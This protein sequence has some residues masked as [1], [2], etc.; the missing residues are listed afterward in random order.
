MEASKA[1][2]RKVIQLEYEYAVEMGKPLFAVV[3]EEASIEK[4][5]KSLGIKVLETENPHKL[6]EFKALVLSKMVRFWCD[7]R[8]IKLAV[9]ETMAEFSRRTELV[10]WISGSEAVNAGALAKEFARLTK[11]NSELREQLTHFSASVGSY[12]GLNY[13]QMHNLLSKTPPDILLLSPENAKILGS[14]AEALGDKNPD[15]LHLLWM[16]SG[17]LRRP[18][19]RADPSIIKLFDGLVDLGL[20]QSERET[21]SGGRYY[22]LTDT[23]RQFLVRFRLERD[24]SKAEQYLL[25][26]LDIVDPDTSA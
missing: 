16:I 8:D 21:R 5:V 20:I 1:K 23:A 10:G 13:E 17:Y 26:K 4:K 7:P 2:V 9:M 24:T 19:H 3:I 22:R 11:E 18:R 6:R 14:I 25:E 15:T 12:G